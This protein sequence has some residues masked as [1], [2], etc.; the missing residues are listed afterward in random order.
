MNLSHL[1]FFTTFL[2]CT[3]AVS[4][5]VLSEHAVTDP[6]APR[7]RADAVRRMEASVP[8]IAPFEQFNVNNENPFIPYSAR[9]AERDAINQKP[10]PTA[11]KPAVEVIAPVA[12]P[13]PRVGQGAGDAPQALG[14]ISRADG[15]Q[16]LVLREGAADRLVAIGGEV[17]AWTLVG[18]ENGTVALWRDARGRVSRHMI[19]DGDGTAAPAT[20]PASKPAKPAAKVESK[21]A[22]PEAGKPAKS[23]SKPSGQPRALPVAPPSAPV[24]K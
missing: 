9:Q 17:G 6:G 22:K 18:I 14:V 7:T 1:V 16:Q 24:R 5:L 23:E 2:L 4:W 13:L 8:S 21:P 11:A 3:A 20:A 19:G 10:K 12:K 15:S